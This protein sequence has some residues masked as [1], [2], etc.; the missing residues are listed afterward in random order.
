MKGKTKIGSTGGKVLAYTL[1]LIGLSGVFL[2]LM[3]YSFSNLMKV[4]DVLLLFLFIVS[5]YLTLVLIY[6]IVTIFYNVDKLKGRQKRR[7]EFLEI[8]VDREGGER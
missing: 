7:F 5:T 8:Q 6:S 2:W 4:F 3:V 1:L